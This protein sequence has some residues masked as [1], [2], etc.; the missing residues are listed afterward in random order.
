MS[1]EAFSKRLTLLTEQPSIMSSLKCLPSPWRK[2]T[3][4]TASYSD[5]KSAVGEKIL[6]QT[7][8]SNISRRSHQRSSFKKSFRIKN[9]KSKSHRLNTISSVNLLNKE[10]PLLNKISFFYK[11]YKLDRELGLFKEMKF[12]EN[13]HGDAFYSSP[14]EIAQLNWSKISKLIVGSQKK[15]IDFISLFKKNSKSSFLQSCRKN[16]SVVRS[17]SIYN[18]GTLMRRSTLKYNLKSNLEFR[19]ALKEKPLVS[20]KH[21]FNQKMCNMH[22]F[23]RQRLSRKTLVSRLV[24]R[25]D[26]SRTCVSCRKMN[27]KIIGK[28][29][30]V[31]RRNIRLMKN[32]SKIRTT[33][34]HE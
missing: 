8:R 13:I 4:T 29:P 19:R 21:C 12:D 17:K 31:A 28:K 23:S 33:L 24:T 25:R 34:N 14:K 11:P 5:I 26:T 15:T 7:P 3:S 6:L 22:K 16:S 20:L 1:T 9:G 32:S 27:G 18:V 2:T 30:V 10:T